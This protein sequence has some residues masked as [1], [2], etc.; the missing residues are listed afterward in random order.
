MYAES[1]DPNTPAEIAEVFAKPRSAEGVQ[2]TTEFLAA[3]ATGAIVTDQL[4]LTSDLI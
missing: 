1:S 3:I 4:P 2:A